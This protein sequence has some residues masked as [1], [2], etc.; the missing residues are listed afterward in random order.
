VGAAAGGL[1]A[2]LEIGASAGIGELAG[3]GATGSWPWAGACGPAGAL[4]TGVEEGDVEGSDACGGNTESMTRS[5][6][7]KT[8][9]CG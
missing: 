5:F 7:K 9:N 3:V 4:V 2:P 1:G 6:S 8:A